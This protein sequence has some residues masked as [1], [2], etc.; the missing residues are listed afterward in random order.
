MH[1]IIKI[2]LFNNL[3]P[4]FL[5]EYYVQP[6]EGLSNSIPTIQLVQ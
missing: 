1:Y 2:K 3:I 6:E 4:T 5:L